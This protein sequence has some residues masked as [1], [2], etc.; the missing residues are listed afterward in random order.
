MTEDYC[1]SDIY[2]VDFG[3]ITLNHVSKLTP[4]YV[5]KLELCAFVSCTDILCVN[6]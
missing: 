4:S 5:K 6:N 1:G 3:N 2:I